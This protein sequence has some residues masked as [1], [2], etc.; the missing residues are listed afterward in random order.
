M[1]G[2]TR[3]ELLSLGW[4]GLTHPDDTEHSMG[5]SRRLL[6]GAVEP[7]QLTKRYVHKNGAIIWVETSDAVVRNSDGR[8][9][10]FVC[11]IQNITQRK[12]T[13]AKLEESQK[14]LKGLIENSPAVIFIKKVDGTYLEISRRWVE[15]LGLDPDAMI[16]KT[17]FDVFPVEQATLYRANDEF[18]FRTRKALEVEETAVLPDGVHVFRSLKFPLF[19]QDGECYALCGV[20]QDITERKRAEQD[21]EDLEAQLKQAQ[22][23]EA[24]GQL[25]GGLAH[26]FNNI[27]AVILNYSSFVAE[28]LVPDDPRSG[29]I[30]EIVKAGEKAALLVH[31]LLAFSRKEV[32]EPEVL[33]LNDVIDDLSGLLGSSIGESIDL[34]IDSAPGLPRILADIGQLEQVLLNLAVNARDAMRDGGVLSIVTAAEELVE[35][36]RPGLASGL[37][38]WLSVTDTGEGMTPATINRIFEPFFTTKVVGEGTGLGLA[39][40]Y[41]IVKQSNG[42]IYV[43]STLEQGTTFHIFLPATDL[44]LEPH[45]AHAVKTTVTGRS[46]AIL[47]VEDES[48]VRELVSRV[49]TK[50][51]YQVTAFAG[52]SEALDFCHASPAVIDLLVTDVVM[53]EMSGKA[54]ADSVLALRSDIKT[55]FM[56]GYTDEIIA[57]R[58]VLSSGQ[59]L[60]TKPFRAAEFVE[61]VRSVLGATI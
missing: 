2:Y 43:D 33:D 32:V 61:K 46:G 35:G 48:S 1:V 30:Q 56:S 34:V 4:I 9:L 53:P 47:V 19:D 25:A 55:I 8:A 11:A 7:H 52:G 36:D 44:A 38:A 12:A 22:R 26:D 10:Y 37:Y 45:P 51:G 17:D 59:H 23:M 29:D 27:L 3:Q 21:R 20:S 13:Q 42:G 60:I 41:G 5:L 49:L 54:L 58:G 40:V 18:V 28:D 57:K 15:E 50:A 24:V 39:T 31:Q 16:G 6:A 14:L